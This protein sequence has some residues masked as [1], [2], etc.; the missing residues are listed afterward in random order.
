MIIYIYKAGWGLRQGR[1][2]SKYP[3]HDTQK[4]KKREKG[5]EK[6]ERIGTFRSKEIMS[7]L[8]KKWKV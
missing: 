6:R 7:T 1:E 5:K 8:S 4:K 3:D 2:L